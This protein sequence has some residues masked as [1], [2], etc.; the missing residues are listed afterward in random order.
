MRREL[1]AWIVVNFL[2]IASGVI[3][4]YSSESRRRCCS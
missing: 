1:T 3:A 4:G 2:A